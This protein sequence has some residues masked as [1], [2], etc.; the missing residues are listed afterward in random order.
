M[1]DYVFQIES[2]SRS[3]TEDSRDQLV[4]WIDEAAARAKGIVDIAQ[5]QHHDVG[6]AREAFDDLAN[7]ARL[8]QERLAQIQQAA[9]QVNT[10][11]QSIRDIAEKTNLLA[12]NAAIEAARAGSAGVGFAVVADEVRRLARSAAQTVQSAAP[13]MD[14]IQASVAGAAHAYDQFSGMVDQRVVQMG[15][16]LDGLS[17]IQER[18]DANREL[19]SKIDAGVRALA[20]SEAHPPSHRETP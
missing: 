14:G 3:R 18:V 15:G 5:T 10:V 19:F 7:Q 12:L 4:Q 1:E 20:D 13:I 11:L 9:R 2:A 8:H 16:I 6:R 17:S